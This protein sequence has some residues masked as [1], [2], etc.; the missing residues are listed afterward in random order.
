MSSLNENKN[1]KSSIS[2]IMLGFFAIFTMN[3]AH[4]STTYSDKEI[5][6]LKNEIFALYQTDN[7]DAALELIKQI[8][9]AKKSEDIYTIES[10]ILEDTQEY[11]SAIENLNKALLI[12]PKNYKVFYNLGCI[13]LKKKAYDLAIKDFEAAI[14]C[15]KD[16]PFAYYNLA[17]CYIALKDY[18][19]AKKYLI[20]AISIKPDEKDFYTNLAFCYKNL[21][22]KKAAE[23]ILSSM[24]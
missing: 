16:F 15:N 20:K 17:S 24:P 8:P 12:N 6:D 3:A 22:D 9:A 2:C 14:K 1:L 13:L 5:L 18:A 19:S 23:R 4:C 10:N 21:G 7:Y 11:A